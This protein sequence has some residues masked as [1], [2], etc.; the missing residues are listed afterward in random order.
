MIR[1]CAFGFPNPD[2]IDGITD[3]TAKT[4]FVFRRHFQHLV[5]SGQVQADSV[6]WVNEMIGEAATC[7][8]RS[9]RRRP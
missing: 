5:D 2:Y 9:V 8:K 7:S 4:V 1:F 6:A 3:A